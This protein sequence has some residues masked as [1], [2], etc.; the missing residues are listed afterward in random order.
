MFGLKTPK[1]LLLTLWEDSFTHFQRVTHIKI[2][3]LWK[4]L[5][6]WP[7]IDPILLI[8]YRLRLARKLTEQAIWAIML[9]N[10]SVTNICAST[11]THLL[12]INVPWRTLNNWCKKLGPFTARVE[13]VHVFPIVIWSQ[14]RHEY[15][16]DCRTIAAGR[17][18]S[19]YFFFLKF[20]KVFL[21]NRPHSFE[22]FEALMTRKPTHHLIR[23]LEI[24]DWNIWILFLWVI[25]QILDCMKI[26]RASPWISPILNS[27]TQTNFPNILQEHQERSLYD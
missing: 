16:K 4:T 2:F 12:H 26:S 15:T 14:W 21:L 1:L 5:T 27:E 20:F 8:L 6:T 10:M 3:L 22:I 25:W 11:V 24:L 13:H 19:S 23:Y 9:V 17:L 18:T 7:F